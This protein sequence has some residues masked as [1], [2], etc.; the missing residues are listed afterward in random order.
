MLRKLCIATLLIAAIV[1]LALP[2]RASAVTGSATITITRTEPTTVTTTN[3]NGS[4]FVLTVTGDTFTSA[5]DT[6]NVQLMGV[7][8]GSSIF[9]QIN[10]PTEIG[11]HILFIGDKT[12]A[13][14]NAYFLVGSSA[15]T[16]GVASSTSTFTIPTGDIY[17][18]EITTLSPAHEAI[19]V[20][21]NATFS[22]TFNEEIQIMN[23]NDI[24]LYKKSDD[25]LVTSVSL[26]S[27]SLDSSDTKLSFTFPDTLGY[28]TT[29]YIVLPDSSIRDG[30]N[31]YY[32][33]VTSWEFTTLIK[34]TVKFDDNVAG[35]TIT[36]PSDQWLNTGDKVSRPSD[37]SRTGYSFGGWFS[38]AACDP[39]DEWDFANT[40]VSGDLTL[41]AKW[42]IENFDLV[43][44]GNGATGGS[45]S[46]ESMTFGTTKNLTANAYTSTDG[47]FLGWNTA[48]DGSG[49][50]YL[51]GASFTMNTEGTTLYAEW[52]YDIS[53]Y[54]DGGTNNAGNP[55]TY[56]GGEPTIA[57][58]D[59][60]KTG[61]IFGGWTSDAAHTSF[62]TEITQGESGDKSLY[63]YW[64]AAPQVITY[65][66][67]PGEG[68]GSD[69]MN[70]Y[71]DLTVY[72]SSGSG[73]TRAGY[74]LDGWSIEGSSYLLGGLY[75]VPAYD[76]DAIAQWALDTDSD[77][78]SD[79]DEVSAGT[80]PNN[81]SD[82]PRKRTI[83]L[84]VLN[85]D[86]TPTSGITCVLNSSPVIAITD[87]NGHV[88]FND[89]YL[90]SHTLSLRSGTT[91]IGTYS[92]DFT[93]AGANASVIADDASTDSDGLVETAVANDFRALNITIQLNGA[94]QWQLMS[95]IFSIYD[96][97][98]IAVN[99][100]TGDKGINIYLII[101]SML[102]ALSTVFILFRKKVFVR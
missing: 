91:Q 76:V 21:I 44:D 70:T 94:S 36:M 68:I 53:Y 95:S 93:R 83:N 28:S 81:S 39:A 40:I 37:P 7:T 88:I 75:D 11:V 78:V 92:L 12:V 35:E 89:V 30:S 90:A 74:V 43:Y 85:N 23:N 1:V 50:S 60:T 41:Y 64:T 10:S 48:S 47:V 97:A 46:S 25:S 63:A 73:F 99:P 6:T 15:L 102:L 17:P 65:T 27:A 42:T 86:G 72:L 14:N 18:P 80:D 101:G 51:D 61:Y 52:E 2:A 20:D 54:L 77:G 57:L 87:A 19:N 66:V 100:H 26:S 56:T 4:Y 69:T 79:N 33:G 16:S 58:L 22:A 49:L 55:S 71:T 34:C 96:P 38:D 84:T 13:Y 59:P 24:N 32:A 8:N 3:L 67:N 29:Y 9:V 31:N 45:M 5:A 98:A 62:V 82:T